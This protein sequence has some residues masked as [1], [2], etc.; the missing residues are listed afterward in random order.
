MDYTLRWSLLVSL[1]AFK[2]YL[3]VLFIKIQIL[4]YL[5]RLKEGMVNHHTK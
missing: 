3:F 1:S 5:L 2:F 4:E